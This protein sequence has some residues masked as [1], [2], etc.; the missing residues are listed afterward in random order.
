VIKVGVGVSCDAIDLICCCLGTSREDREGDPGKEKPAARADGK[1]GASWVKADCSPDPRN[2]R[3]CKSGKEMGMREKREGVSGG[4][5]VVV[6][7]NQ[8]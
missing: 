7:L 6:S 5:D 4:G 2:D 8:S 3:D 1:E